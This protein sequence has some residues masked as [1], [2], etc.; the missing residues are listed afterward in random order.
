MCGA[1]KLDHC[2][3]ISSVY[4]ACQPDDTDETCCPDDNCVYNGNCYESGT[5][6]DVDGDGFDEKCVA[7]SN[8]VWEETGGCSVDSDC[9]HC[10]EKCDV[11]GL[12]TGTPNTCYDFRPIIAGTCRYYD[13][14]ENGHEP[15]D[16]SVPC[17]YDDGGY[18]E[19]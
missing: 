5:L 6:M 9:T 14:C 18:G 19:H 10:Y 8:G 2:C 17:D 12:I 7:G 15:G 3:K 13:W 1:K 11:D 4:Y 16:P